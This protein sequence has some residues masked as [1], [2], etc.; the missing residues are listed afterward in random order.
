MVRVKDA[1]DE[2]GL[3]LVVDVDGS[4]ASAAEF[5]QA[6]GLNERAMQLLVV[7]VSVTVIGEHETDGLVTTLLGHGVLT[8]LEIDPQH[9]T[10]RVAV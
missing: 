3:G 9:I 2:V 8:S 10:E 5:E 7:L 4:M 6:A 1:D